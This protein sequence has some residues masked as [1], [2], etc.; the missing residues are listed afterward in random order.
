MREIRPTLR[1]LGEKGHEPMK[2]PARLLVVDDEE[3]ILHLLTEFLTGKGY[4]VTSAANSVACLWALDEFPDI[5]V[6]LLDNNMPGVTG[7]DL[8]PQIKRLKPGIGVI[9]LTALNDWETS[10][11][12]LRLGA[13]DYVVKPVN[14]SLLEMVVS[15][16]LRALNYESDRVPR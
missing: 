2:E 10:Q 4:L 8:L 14:L 15:K 13:F 3:A 6:I 5:R 11:E 16:C 7:L 12:A 1:S 9:I